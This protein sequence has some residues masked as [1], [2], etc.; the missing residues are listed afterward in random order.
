MEFPQKKKRTLKAKGTAQRKSKAWLYILILTKGTPSVA[1]IKRTQGRNDGMG[2]DGKVQ[3]N[4]AQFRKDLKLGA[5][6]V[7]NGGNICRGKVM[8]ANL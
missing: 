8:R 5:C 3:V 1:S 7:D 4:W 2:E 6:S